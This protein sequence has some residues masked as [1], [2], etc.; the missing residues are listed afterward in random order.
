MNE[1]S[2]PERAGRALSA[3]EQVELFQ[4]STCIATS[5]CIALS[6]YLYCYKYFDTVVWQIQC[7]TECVTAR[8]NTPAGSKK[9]GLLVL[10]A[11]YC[12]REPLSVFPLVSHASSPSPPPPLPPPLSCS[13]AKSTPLKLEGHRCMKKVAQ[14]CNNSRPQ[15]HGRKELQSLTPQVFLTPTIEFF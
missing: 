3:S 9:K 13:V 8:A 5:T 4:Q 7:D 14:I 11:A 2:P 6:K 1:T 10:P 12:S 15:R